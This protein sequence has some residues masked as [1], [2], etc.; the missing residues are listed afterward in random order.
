MLVHFREFNPNI[1]FVDLFDYLLI[2]STVLWNPLLLP[3]M[4]SL[5]LPQASMFSNSL[6]SQDAPEQNKTSWK[7]PVPVVAHMTSL[8][9]QDT[10]ERRRTLYKFV[11]WDGVN[12]RGGQK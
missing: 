12:L 7:Q 6:K 11:K 9:L 8:S 1:L 2:N 3:K 4:W 10:W 5:Y